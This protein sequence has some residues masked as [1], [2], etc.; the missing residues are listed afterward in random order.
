MKLTNT[1]LLKPILLLILYTISSVISECDL[2]QGCLMRKKFLTYVTYQNKHGEPVPSKTIL[3][4]K[5][6]YV[7]LDKLIIY[8]SAK[9][10][11]ARIEPEVAAS[12]KEDEEKIERIINFG[13][14]ILD[15]G[16]THN[17]LCH[18]SEYNGLMDK[19]IFQEIKKGIMNSPDI[20]CLVIPFFEN[21]YKLVHE[22][23]GVYL[24]K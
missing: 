2:K 14:I 10:A 18:I 3:N 8:G 24:Y 12:K 11:D 16:K 4:N 9:A 15:C 1:K 19:P 21:G 5:I 22:K 7:F 6:V 17:K 23:N 13:E 20:K